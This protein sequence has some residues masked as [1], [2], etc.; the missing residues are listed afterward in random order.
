MR[1]K[2]QFQGIKTLEAMFADREQLS[3]EELK[4]FES[5]EIC[6]GG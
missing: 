2:Q 5:A 6:H 3:V 4:P 1:R